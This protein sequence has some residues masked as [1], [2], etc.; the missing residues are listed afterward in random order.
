MAALK[1]HDVAIAGAGV[2]GAATAFWLKRLEPSLDIVLI[3]RDPSFAQA[4]SSLSAIWPSSCTRYS[5]TI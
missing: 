5:R 3:E 1:T 4:S 2:M